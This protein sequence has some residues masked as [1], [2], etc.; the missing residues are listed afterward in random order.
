M[1]QTERTVFCENGGGLEPLRFLIV[2]PD[3]EKLAFLDAGTG[4]GNSAGLT[5]V[6]GDQQ[7]KIAVGGAASL[8]G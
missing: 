3:G 8:S 5:V 2:L 1:L 6:A 7:T 4:T